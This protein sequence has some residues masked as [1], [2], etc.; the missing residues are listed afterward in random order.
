MTKDENLAPRF[1][2]RPQVLLLIS[3]LLY[4][5]PYAVGSF[6]YRSPFGG[7]RVIDYHD[8]T[9]YAVV[10]ALLAVAASIFLTKEKKIT[11][12]LKGSYGY[13]SASISFLIICLLIYILVFSPDL[14]S[15]RK[16]EVLDATNR[17]HYIFYYACSIGLVFSLMT[18]WK[19]NIPL[20]ILSLSGLAIALYIGHRSYLAIAI[21]GVGYLFFRNRSILRVSPLYYVGIF[22]IVLFLA[23]YKS[24]YVA[25]KMGN[26]NAVRERLTE[27]PLA[28]NALV[29]LEQFVTF[30]HLDFVVA[31]NYEMPCTNL[32]LVPVSIIPFMDEFLDIAT[33]GYNE[34]V[35]ATFF[36]GYPGG[37]AGNIWAEFFAV[38][39]Y[40]GIPL[41]VI[42][43]IS[44]AKAIEYALSKI[45][46]PL[47]Q[48]GLII[49]M[50]EIS[51]YIQ[52]KEL[53]S[54]FVTAKRAIIVAFIAYAISYLVRILVGKRLRIPKAA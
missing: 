53:M 20:I 23:V 40:F 29:G 50:I 26:F 6:V 54:A 4:F 3:T 44:I 19:R 28:D 34:Q 24:V 21:G 17:F 38:F 45:G 39:G 1:S 18:G 25:I 15:P 51:V 35:Q 37:V 52:R 49:A 27:N 42:V 13:E 2:L 12:S 46:N 31:F 10:L 22:L 9:I 30:A 32:W 11:F 7:R 36:S 43:I 16:A 47:L 5:F 33:C 14:F 48:S 8:V 41:V